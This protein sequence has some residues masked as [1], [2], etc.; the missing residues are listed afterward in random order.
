MNRKK[1]PKL[2]VLKIESVGKAKYQNPR[3]EK[4]VAELSKF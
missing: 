4:Q 2:G 1:N 3:K